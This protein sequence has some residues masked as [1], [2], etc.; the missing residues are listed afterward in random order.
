MMKVDLVIENG[1]LTAVIV[2]CVALMIVE[3]PM[4]LWRRFMIKYLSY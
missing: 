3:F 2:M 1:K 4:C